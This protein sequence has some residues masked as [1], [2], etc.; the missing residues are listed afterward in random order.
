MPSERSRV[1]HRTNLPPCSK[2][3]TTIDCSCRKSGGR[4]R[5]LHDP[6]VPA[7]GAPVEDYPFGPQADFHRAAVLAARAGPRGVVRLAQ[8]RRLGRERDHR[9]S[10][11]RLAT[12]RTSVRTFAA[13]AASALA[14]R[15]FGATG[16][17]GRQGI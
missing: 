7:F 4:L 15:G 11:Y 9:L 6:H 13:Y 1:S 5:R 10:D 12:A 8:A 14:L 17:R 2:K 16:R 3:E